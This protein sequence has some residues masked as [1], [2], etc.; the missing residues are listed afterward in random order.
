MKVINRN[1]K[2]EDM[3]FDKITKRLKRLNSTDSVVDPIQIS[4][5]VVSHISDRITTKELDELSGILCMEMIDQHPDYGKL[6]ARIAIDNHHKNTTNNFLNCCQILY[7]NTD[8]L[9]K[10]S[11]LINEQLYNIVKNNHEKIEEMINYEKDFKLNYFGFQTL[12]KSYLLRVN[13]KVIER[14][15]HL[16][17]RVS[18]AIHGDN[19]DLVKETYDYMSDLMMI[20]ATPTLFHA[21]TPFQQLCSCFLTTTP[22][23][24]EGIFDT[25]KNVALLSK[26]AGGVG[27]SISDLRAEGS[28][29]RKT[30]GYSD[31]IVPFLKT[32]NSLARY[33]NQ[34]GKRLGSFAMYIEP[35]HADI[36]KFLD[37][38]KNHGN[39]EE[40]ARDLFYGL[41]IPDLFM[42]CVET[43]D[44][45]YLMCPDE[46]EGL[47][48]TYGVEFENKYN[49]Y[50]QQGKFREMVKARDLFVQI[51]VSQRETGLPYMLY[52]DACNK[53]NNQKNLGTIKCSNLCTEIVEYSDEKEYAVCNLASIALSKCVSYPEITFNSVKM[54]VI[55]NCQWCLLSKGLMKQY[56]INC[57][58]I[59]CKTDQEKNDIK[60]Q[61]NM[62]TFPQIIIDDKVIGGYSKF[63]K[64]VQ[65][66]FNFET[67]RK[68]V[69]VVT[70][71]LNIIIDKNFYPIIE[72]KISNLK[73]RPIGIGVQ[74]LADM[75]IQ[76]G[77][78]F[79]SQEANQL[80]E[81]IFEYI[82]YYALETSCEET[83]SYNEKLNCIR[84]FKEYIYYPHNDVEPNIQTKFIDKC[85]FDNLRKLLENI[86][87]TK[88]E[89]N[90]D[91]GYYS[92]YEGSY[93]S[94]G[95]FQ[96][97]LFEGRKP[98]LTLDWEKLRDNI[99]K[100][101][102]RNSLLLAPM[103]TASTSQI[104]GN[105]ECIEPY[106]SNLYSRRTLSGE[107][108]VINQWL[109]RDLINIGL[110][111]KEIRDKLIY[112]RGSVQKIIEIPKY[113]RDLYKT[114]W[115]I[116]Q[117]VIVDL[118]DSRQFFI[119]Q[120]QSLNVFMETPTTPLLLKYHLYSWKK[121]LKTGSYYIRSKPAVNS[122]QFTLDPN[123]KRKIELEE[124]VGCEMCSA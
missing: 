67:L 66:Y 80:N 37:A 85:V 53:R 108:T 11:P 58:I 96:F 97:E 1:G 2:L 22:D 57:E 116:K 95:K 109:F 110:W 9:G 27:Q 14:P 49:K 36:Y 93:I 124:Q 13:K 51:T 105:N 68:I 104:L 99:K 123:I 16:F 118:A 77:L 82:Y 52:K 91:K 72:T 101:G 3:E 44:C 26:W 103:P 31:G 122:Q 39:E 75:F 107:F 89:L 69:K 65:P 120:S 21:G 88:Q 48:N 50:V 98:N 10:K 40:R 87:P 34:S 78:P 111:T 28:Y 8:V 42:K 114:A 62:S 70:K 92:S 121:G 20:H 47:T 41:W 63:K 17:M 54:Y 32:K 61:N 12:M 71:N 115:E 43:D 79:D 117:K 7:D 15:Q 23:S 5:K 56:N 90:S 102:V 60:T 35:W 100:H 84:F 76:L 30:G 29:I 83:Q 45:W 33:I 38:K 74:G 24:V 19:F 113:L 6:G 73:H 55:E 119:D 81:K 25:F 59:E 64:L 106:T 46:C 94:E 18:I 4:Q 86:Q 112:Y